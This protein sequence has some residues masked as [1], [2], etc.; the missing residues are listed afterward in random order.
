MSHDISSCYDGKIQDLIG[1]YH[2]AY[3]A[4]S[5]FA[6]L[7]L[8]GF[9]AYGTNTVNIF[10]NAFFTANGAKAVF[11]KCMLARFL[12]N[13]RHNVNAYD[14]KAYKD[15]KPYS[16]PCNVNFVFFITHILLPAKNSLMIYFSKVPV[17][18]K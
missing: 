17:T 5:V 18:F 3:G 6:I 16:H 8:T 9:L 1:F 13:L 7:M 4:Y 11:S 15:K 10:M 12:K 14:D 2:T